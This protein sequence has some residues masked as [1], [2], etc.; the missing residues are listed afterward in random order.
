MHRF[1]ILVSFLIAGTFVQAEPSPSS[2]RI[3]AVVNRDIITKADLMN[4]LRFAALL[5]ELD[6]TPENLERMKDQMLRVLIDERLQVQLGKKYKI[7]ITKEQIASAIQDIEHGNGMLPGSTLKMMKEN[8]IPYKTLEDQI[9]AQLV[10]YVFIHEKYPL[11]TLTEQLRK[12]SGQ[13]Y[14]PSL[15]ISDWEIDEEF[16]RQKEKTQKTQYHLAE[17]VLHVDNLEHE[18]AVKKNLNQL[19]EELQKG[20]HFTAIAQQ[21]SES[22]TAAQLGDMGW[23]TEEQ[24]E[25]EIKEALADMQPGQISKPIRTSGGY[26]VLAFIERK[27]PGDVQE[28]KRVTLRQV[29]LPLPDPMTEEKA[30]AMMNKIQTMAPLAK[31]CYEFET[32]AKSKFPDAISR[33]LP[34]QPLANF[35]EPLQKV[36]NSLPLN[37]MSDPLITEEGAVL[38]MVCNTNIEKP[39]EITLDDV[40]EIIAKRKY[41]LLSQQE[42]QELRRHAFI[43]VR[44]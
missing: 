11:K 6:P 37:K 41:A 20:A 26:T 44:M 36:I 40:K 32:L 27:T 10:F 9:R 22:A 17:I 31:D 28:Q 13:E 38:I 8:N 14:S 34:S 1:L 43:E 30:Q 19:I 7:D 3:A 24:L 18:E 16:K 42:L 12:K 39:E 33:L 25:S 2:S 35:P 15:Q 5:S 4:R 29:L 21:F 23:L